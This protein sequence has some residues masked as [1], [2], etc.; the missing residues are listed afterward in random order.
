MVT[1]I[2]MVS[3]AIRVSTIAASIYTAIPKKWKQ[4]ARPLNLGKSY[5]DDGSSVE[6][7]KHGRDE[8]TNVS[9][10]ICRRICKTK[11]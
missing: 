4:P 3:V 9:L 8:I 11:T 10:D 7:L 1:A 5:D 2:G 6:L